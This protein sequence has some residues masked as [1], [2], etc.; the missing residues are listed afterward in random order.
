MKMSKMKKYLSLILAGI[1]ATG[2]LTACSNGK[3]EVATAGGETAGTAS[4]S[5][6]PEG[7]GNSGVQE[8]NLRAVSFGNNY[9]VQD[10]GWRFM[11]VGSCFVT[12]GTCLLNRN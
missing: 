8:L 4:T 9:D 1:L 7:S 10:M 3:T 12:C 11:G 6:T 5:G 2:L